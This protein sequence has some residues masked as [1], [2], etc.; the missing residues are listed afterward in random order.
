MTLLITKAWAMPSKN[1]FTIKP[2]RQI[3]EKYAHGIIVDP[4]AN[5][6]KIATITNDL[7]P[8][9][10]TDYNLDAL[11]FLKILQNNS[12]NTVLYDPPFSPRQVSDCYRKMD[13]TVNKETT[14][15]S[16]WAKLKREITRVIMP[17]GI[18]ISAGWNSGGIGKKL[19]FE[20]IEIL[21]VAHGG[22]R[23]DT[24]V[25]IERLGR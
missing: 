11:D 6:S 5:S 2:I 21:L 4:F 20:Q 18:V 10:D 1:T 25:T 9:F 7:D 8:A 14:Q 12:A 23:N 22:G 19:G 16:F 17:Q 3:V 15:K 13:R 24:I